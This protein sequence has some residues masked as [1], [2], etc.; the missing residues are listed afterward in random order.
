MIFEKMDMIFGL[1]KLYI[2]KLVYFNRI[3]FKGVPKIYSNFKFYIRK[4]AKLDLGVGIRFRNNFTVRLEKKAILKIGDKCFF[5]DGCS[6]NCRK[7]IEIGNGV[8][9]GQNVIV[10]DHDHDYRDNIKNFKEENIKIGNN[11][12]IGANSIILKGVTVAA[13]SIVNKNIEKNS[14]LYQKKVNNIKN[15]ERK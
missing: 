13:N 2:F 7:N 9:F 5:N 14:I 11:V 8:L 15:I 4:N 12:W 1:L 10:L 3:T 6:I